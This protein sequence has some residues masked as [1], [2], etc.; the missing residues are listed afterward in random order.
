LKP[1]IE[2][3]RKLR[4]MVGVE[5]R[6]FVPAAVDEALKKGLNEFAEKRVTEAFKIKQKHE[7]R[8]A[9]AAIHTEAAAKLLGSYSDAEK[10]AKEKELAEGEAR[11]L[12][13]QREREAA[14]AEA[15]RRSALEKLASA[16]REK[17]ANADRE[18]TRL[19]SLRR[20]QELEAELERQAVLLSR[21]IYAN[22]YKRKEHYYMDVDLKNLDSSSKQ[23][24]PNSAPKSE[25]SN[26][27][28]P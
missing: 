21:S 19:A 26:P 15:A 10:A 22:D 20:Q 12:A 9:L 13:E 23:P 1:I 28:K 4:E 18:A 11:R 25:S 2:M 3:Q 5:K 8:D 27:P 14:D 17:R 6:K 16:E 7:R 24:T